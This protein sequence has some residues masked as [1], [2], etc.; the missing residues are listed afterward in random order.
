MVIVIDI[1]ND[2]ISCV[3]FCNII[4]AIQIFELDKLTLPIKEYLI[5]SQLVRN[6]YFASLFIH[7]YNKLL[8]TLL[9]LMS[10]INF[11]SIIKITFMEITLEPD[12]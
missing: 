10:I 2:Q 5:I 11:H 7:L 8:S 12:V 4:N 3:F 9:P 1:T 6:L